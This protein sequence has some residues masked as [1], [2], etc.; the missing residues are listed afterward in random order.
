MNFRLENSPLACIH[1]GNFIMRKRLHGATTMALNLKCRQCGEQMTLDLESTRVVCKHCGYSPLDDNSLEEKAA[2]LRAKPRQQVKITHR[3]Q[4][5]ANAMAAF[6]TGHDYLYQE[7][8]VKAIDSFKRSVQFQRDFADA[9]LWIAQLADDEKTKRHHLSMI[10]A[11]HPGHLEATRALMVLNGKL[12]P[13]Q[14]ERSEHTNDLKIQRAET[15]VE[16]QTKALLCPTCMGHLTVHEQTG[17]VVCKFCGYEGEHPDIQHDGGDVLLTEA[18]IRRKAQAVKWVIGERLLHC[19]QCGAERTIAGDK[20]STVCTFCGSNQVI[21]QDAL[22]SFEQPDSLIPFKVSRDEAG[23]LIKEKLNSLSERVVGWFSNNEVARGRLE[24]VYLPFWVFDAT[25]EITRTKTYQASTRNG[26][27]VFVPQ[28]IQTTEVFQDGMFNV[29]VCGVT[30]PSA[31]LTS[32]LAPFEMDEA[33]AYDPRLLAKYPAELYDIDFD[34]A[35]LEARGIVS[36]RMR[37]KHGEKDFGEENYK[38]SVMCMV[39]SMSF[40]LVLMPVWIGTLIEKDK[41]VRQALVNGQT[42]EVVLGK[43]R[44]S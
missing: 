16:G 34:K 27:M 2:E 7:D 37:E 40:R 4:I 32:K 10:L 29:M 18:L 25:A 3:G 33:A 39:Q 28:Q 17:R 23:N 6:N 12:T 20:L 9:H 22:N 42:G 44:R 36:R 5:N 41:D 15:P 14:A 13:E 38:I 8:K 30:S 43:A 11:Y 24:G 1:F 31:E 19:N 21:V 35:S 26:R